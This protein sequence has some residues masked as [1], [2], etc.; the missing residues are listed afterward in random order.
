MG[1]DNGLGEGNGG[2][3]MNNHRHLVIRKFKKLKILPMG[4]ASMTLVS[5]ALNLESVCEDSSRLRVAQF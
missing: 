3:L 4:R 5:L 2:K 1:G